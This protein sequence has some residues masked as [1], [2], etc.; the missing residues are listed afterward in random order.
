MLP[1][2]KHSLVLLKMDE[3]IARNT[4]SWLKLL[5]KLLLLHLVGCLYYFIPF[6]NILNA[7]WL[8][9]KREDTPNRLEYM[10]TDTGGRSIAG[11]AV[12]NPAWGMDVC[13]LWT[14]CDVQ[15]K[16]PATGRSLVQG[17]PAGC[18]CVWSGETI[19]LYAYTKQVQE[20]WLKNINYDW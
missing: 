14:L 13:P 8:T 6:Y 5:I 19:T 10:E 7:I 17:C 15:V 4:L 18:V 9:W 3:I 1:A 12:S 11:T 16:A 2:S 20:G